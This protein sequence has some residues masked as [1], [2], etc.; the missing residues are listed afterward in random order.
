MEIN[1][2]LRLNAIDV[3]L[4]SLKQEMH[5]KPNKASND[6]KIDILK[7]VMEEVKEVKNMSAFDLASYAKLD[8]VSKTYSHCSA[9]D[10]LLAI[11]LIERYYE[12]R[13]LKV[14]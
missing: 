9:L 13:N 2:I 10:I 8:E 7:S 11:T 1:I 3:S 4:K 12:E 6:Q 5:L 14:A